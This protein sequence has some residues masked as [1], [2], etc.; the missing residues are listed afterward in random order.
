MSRLKGGAKFTM[1]TAKTVGIVGSVGLTAVTVA[2]QFR[3]GGADQ[4][5]ITNSTPVAA[6][7]TVPSQAS[8]PAPGPDEIG[9]RAVKSVFDAYENGS[10]GK[11]KGKK[12]TD[13]LVAGLKATQ[14][15]KNL[16][17]SQFDSYLREAVR[18][19]FDNQ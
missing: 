14:G 17:G 5:A 9:L 3:G 6:T 4:A 1:K 16:I 19:A 12:A 11:G 8:A 7:G 2:N 18:R 15:V 10:K 13:A